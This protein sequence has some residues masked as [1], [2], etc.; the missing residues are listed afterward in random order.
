[1]AGKTKTDP[2]A[3]YA[4]LFWI[5]RSQAVR[6]PEE[7]QFEGDRV[8]ISRVSAGVLI[9]PLTPG[10][11]ETPEELFARID[12]MGADPL[13]P[14]GRKQNLAPIRDVT[15]DFPVNEAE[16]DYTYVPEHLAEKIRDWSDLSIGQRLT[17][18]DEMRAAAWAKIGVVRDPNKPTGS[19][20]ASAMKL[21]RPEVSR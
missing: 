18:V 16:F 1:M 19:P 3:G 17:L 5:G 13:F 9:E 12:A 21:M 15:D 8:R 14:E 11:K 6:L 10:V 20:H 4:E 7:F 2:Q